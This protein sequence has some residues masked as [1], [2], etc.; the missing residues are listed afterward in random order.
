MRFINIFILII[1][2]VI[3]VYAIFYSY[4]NFY[5]EIINPKQANEEVLNSKVQ[6]GIYFGS[7]DKLFLVETN[8]ALTRLA[9]PTST[10]IEENFDDTNLPAYLMQSGSLYNLRTLNDTF[11]VFDTKKAMNITNLSKP[12]S[13]INFSV[14]QDNNLIVFQVQNTNTTKNDIEICK[15]DGSNLT[16]LTN[17]G[18]SYFP[19]FSPDN[20]R[21]GFWRKNS[22]IYTMK[23]DGTDLKKV[24][25]F[26]QNI[27]QIYAWR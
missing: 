4:K 27:N 14:S 18:E 19:V 2:F 7:L 15:T 3:F 12:Y 13:V 22:G 25:N 1:C 26:D 8:A 6:S 17:D 9:N 20:T 5:P 11:N 23:T 21:I 10:V 16:Q 24:F